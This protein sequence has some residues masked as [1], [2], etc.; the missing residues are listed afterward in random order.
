MHDSRHIL[1]AVNELVHLHMPSRESTFCQNLEGGGPDAII[2]S[3]QLP[4]VRSAADAA[5]QG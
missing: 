1:H 2:L 3:L 5:L 4:Q